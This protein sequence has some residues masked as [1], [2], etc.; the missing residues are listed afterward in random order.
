MTTR[1]QTKSKAA[2]IDLDEAAKFLELLGE[3]PYTFQTFDDNAA[4]KD[5]KLAKIL[6]GEL[7]Q[8][9][10]RLCELNRRG[11][12]IF[13]ALNKT[14]G[15]GR[16][17]ENVT[18]VR[19]NSL[20]LDGQPLDPVRGCKL[21][22]HIIVES[23]PGRY[24]VYWLVTDE[25]LNEF[26]DTQRGIAK[27]FEGDPAI[28]KLTHC[29]RLPGFFHNKAEPFR[30]R[31]K[32]WYAHAA[33]DS[34]HFFEEF[35]AETKRHRA[36]GSR[37]L[38]LPAGAPLK[39]AE[40]FVRRR[41]MQDDVWLLRVYR[42]TF[43][44]WTGTHY[45]EFPDASLERELYGFFDEAWLEAKDGNIVPFN[46]NK[47]KIDQVVHALRRCLLIEDQEAPCWLDDKERAADN[48]VACHNGILDLITRELEPHSPHFFS[49]NCLPLDYDPEA[50]KARRW[51][52]FLVEL[53]PEDVEAEDCLQEIFGYLLTTDTRQEKI[54]LIVG[55]KRGGK[56]T[57]VYVL[58]QLL[59]KANVTFQTLKSMGGEFG[60]WPL[61]DKTLAV[62]ADARLG[63]KADA[64]A[65]AE[66]LLSISGSDAQTI[67]RKNQSFWHGYLS[68]RFLITTNELPAITD[69][70]GTLP[71]R[72]VVLKLTESF[73]GCEDTQLKAKLRLELPGILNWALDGLR[74]LNKRGHFEMPKSS[75]ESVRALEDL[76]SPISAF[77]RDYCEVGANRRIEKEQLYGAWK[78][79]C[80][81]QGLKPSSQIIF[82]RGICALHPS[83][84]PSHSMMKR[85]YDGIELNRAGAAEVEEAAD[86]APTRKR[87]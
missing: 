11:A 47:T 6:H 72:F 54:F 7:A 45:R 23:S 25:E 8:H 39:W 40:E 30:T 27:R 69:A 56:G 22:P 46:P 49:T 31:I 5:R 78:V 15:K 37:G 80:E 77:V 48:L 61:I 73:Y 84:R 17:A 20:D 29:A 86:A 60:R 87:W 44:L 57:L 79:W 42:D 55:P 12:G 51:R 33:Y 3:G 35:P 68:V 21:R 16:K 41:H 74:W 83:V 71:S 32:E 58:T 81:K 13:V 9:V 50:P 36:P 53:W 64:H 82:G 1:E 19:A 2:D 26:E 43:Y 62:I 28:D 18:A 24:H 75:Q 52:K 14:D 63:P 76:A 10:D 70:S 38:M 65:I 59:G 85:Y 34:D 67:N 66:Q 4:R